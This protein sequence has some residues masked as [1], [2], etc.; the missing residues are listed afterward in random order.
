VPARGLV[1]LLVRPAT[2]TPFLLA[3]RLFLDT[4]RG[5]GYLVLA[6]KPVPG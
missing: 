2:M 6:R 4:D 5:D 1:R 3:Q